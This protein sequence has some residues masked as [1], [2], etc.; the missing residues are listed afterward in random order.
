MP[1]QDIT[2]GP[3]GVARLSVTKKA[4]DEYRLRRQPKK[5]SAPA[6][7]APPV[8]AAEP[9]VTAQ[10]E[11]DEGPPAPLEV[12]R[13][14]VGLS[15]PIVQEVTLADATTHTIVAPRAGWNALTV[16]AV[17][18]VVGAALFGSSLDAAVLLQH[19]QSLLPGDMQHSDSMSAVPQHQARTNESTVSYEDTKSMEAQ[20]PTL[21][22]VVA[23]GD[24]S[25]LALIYSAA[26]QDVLTM[27]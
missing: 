1:L 6:P 11:V 27:M 2:N 3:V 22:D 14:V 10:E 26:H 25:A 9:T 8:A 15:A 12:E 21:A 19:G 24:A 20:E 18:C 23:G 5:Q 13:A 7:A 4:R 16:V 17:V